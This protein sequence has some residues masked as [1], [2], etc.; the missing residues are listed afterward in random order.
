ML[1]LMTTIPIDIERG[2]GTTEE[3]E[4]ETVEWM[5]NAVNT[6]HEYIVLETDCPS[7]H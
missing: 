7:N 3:K 2:G 4:K 1:N 5:K 6:M